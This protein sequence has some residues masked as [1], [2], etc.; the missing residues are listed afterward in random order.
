VVLLAEHA[1]MAFSI[2]SVASDLGWDTCGRYTPPECGWERA[3]YG[4]YWV[5]TVCL[6]DTSASALPF[7]FVMLLF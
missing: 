3:G 1:Y 2:F 7:L 4:T 5:V 6:I